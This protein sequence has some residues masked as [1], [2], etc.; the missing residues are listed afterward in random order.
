MKYDIERIR[1]ATLTETWRELRIYL[2][3]KAFDL[4]DLS[5]MPISLNPFKQTIEVRARNLAYAK[6]T[7][8]LKQVELWSKSEEASAEERAKDSF[9][10]DVQ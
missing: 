2:A 4:R 1:K 7:E 3:D 5:Q 6:L 10:V 8:M 9:I